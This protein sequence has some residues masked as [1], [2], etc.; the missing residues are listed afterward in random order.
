MV[1]VVY[2]RIH[3]CYWGAHCCAAQLLENCGAKL[4][5]IEFHNKPHSPEDEFSWEITREL[6]RKQVNEIVEDAQAMI[7]DYICVH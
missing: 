6:I 4:K 7:C 3:A 1:A 2:R 5:D